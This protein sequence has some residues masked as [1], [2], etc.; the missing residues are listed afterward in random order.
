MSGSS[1]NSAGQ[2]TPS[3]RALL[4]QSMQLNN[5]HVSTDMEFTP[6]ERGLDQIESQTRK[7][8]AKS[9]RGDTASGVTGGMD[10][11]VKAHYL[12][13]NRG[14]DPEQLQQNLNAI[15]LAQTFE[16]LQPLH[17]TDIEG[18][19]KH[20]HETLIVSAIEEGRKQ[21]LAD[22]RTHVDK[23]MHND[24]EKTKKRIFEEV[25][26][27][28]IGPRMQAMSSASAS[29]I[30]SQYRISSQTPYSQ[31]K[32]SAASLTPFT[33]S[34]SRPLQ[35]SFTRVS[36]TQPFVNINTKVENYSK[37]V[38]DLNDH[39]IQNRDFAALE[40][41]S[42]V[43]RT[44]D[45]S[46]PS[47]KV[48]HY[49]ESIAF[50]DY[51]SNT[52][53][54]NLKAAK[55][56]GAPNIQSKVEAFLRLR[57]YKYG[58]WEN[59]KLELVDDKP[60]WAHIYFLVRCGYLDEAKVFANRYAE[61]LMQSDDRMF[62]SYLNGYNS[63]HGR[64]RRHAET[65]DPYKFALYKLMGRCDL[66]RKQ[67]PE[68][69]ISAEDWL[70]VQLMLVKE[71]TSPDEPEHER[72]TL[73]DLQNT[74]VH[75]G[76]KY[77][78]PKGNNPFKYFGYLILCG[79]F[80][81]AVAHLYQ[82]EQFQIEAVHFAIAFAYYGLI[83]VPEHVHL[84]DLESG[85]FTVQFSISV[86]VCINVHVSVD[87]ITN[88]TYLN[89]AVLIRQYSRSFTSHNPKIALHYVLLLGL[90]SRAPEPTKSSMMSVAHDLIIEVLLNL[91]DSQL[92]D[93]IGDERRD[94]SRKAGYL[95]LLVPLVDI[96]DLNEYYQRI[97]KEA[98]LIAANR[99]KYDDAR[100]MY[101]YA[102]EYNTV[103]DLLN[104]QLGDILRQGFFAA[105]GS[106]TELKPV[107]EQTIADA[108]LI[109][110]TYRQTADIN[111]KL[112]ES[113]SVTCQ[114]LLELLQFQRLYQERKFGDAL[115][116]CSTFRL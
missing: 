115:N 114:S 11:D 58:R 65:V 93:F 64:I 68:V 83:R 38:V 1:F 74:L 102:G 10:V 76:P 40:A 2:S 56:G 29:P 49:W 82:Y 110:E 13:A 88:I 98:A 14:F 106:K 80:E 30:D 67:I 57:L 25:G 75:F 20:Q 41:F 104:R 59:H 17:D 53:E 113:K 51:I 34:Q 31:A 43:A 9:A 92:R 84:P 54:S 103:I 45:D 112:D 105:S 86:R 85:N 52:I 27:H 66:Q 99:E 32:S 90:Y 70:W 26:Q 23:S 95:E 108:S 61:Y 33:P 42:Q 21:T 91:D 36:A 18:F 77:F 63:E 15:N 101:H 55:A 97:V 96:S 12:L 5:K 47:V 89:F 60:I 35:P 44:F 111:D 72:Y 37:S 107:I 8:A 3:F 79:L 6:I 78:D 48:Y 4:E 100:Y 62:L 19:L 24:W 109:V 7:L 28:P 71:S 87:N 16:P 50:V 81:R 94:G 22:F 46:G 69:A 73:R 116:V 39:R